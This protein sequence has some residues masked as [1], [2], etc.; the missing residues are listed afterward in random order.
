MADDRTEF[1]YTPDDPLG[2]EENKQH[3]IMWRDRAY[4]LR[5]KAEREAQRKV[6]AWWLGAAVATGSLYNFIKPFIWPFK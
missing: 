1:D 5:K 6:Y 2:P 3:R 4:F